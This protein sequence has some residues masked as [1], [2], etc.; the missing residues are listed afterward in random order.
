MKK[1]FYLLIAGIGI[2]SSCGDGASNSSTIPTVPSFP[3]QPSTKPSSTNFDE[4]SLEDKIDYLT[5]CLNPYKDKIISYETGYTE[6]LTSISDGGIE[7]YSK[8]TFEATRYSI[9]SSPL[10]V[11]SGKIENDEEKSEEY[12]MQMYHDSSKIYHLYNYH[13]D[14]GKIK[15]LTDYKGD[16]SSLT[17]QFIDSILNDLDKLIGFEGNNTEVNIVFEEGETIYLS[18]EAI[19]YNPESKSSYISTKAEWEFVFNGNVISKVKN[20]YESKQVAGVTQSVHTVTELSFK[21]EDI[22]EFDGTLYNPSDFSQI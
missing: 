5:N 6:K 19:Q 17:F 15:D 14:S 18:Y 3:T 8:D 21:Y 12:D 4:L 10:I 13:G 9:T 1:A 2:L 11:R 20:S 22:Q 16:D 7:L